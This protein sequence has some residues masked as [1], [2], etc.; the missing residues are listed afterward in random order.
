MIDMEMIRR[1]NN[2]D[3]DA[4]IR[5]LELNEDRLYNWLILDS[6]TVVREDLDGAIEYVRAL[7]EVIRDEKPD[8]I[9]PY[10]NLLAI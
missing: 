10:E 6:P 9:S 8:F 2:Q 1:L 5:V 4:L 7:R 3:T